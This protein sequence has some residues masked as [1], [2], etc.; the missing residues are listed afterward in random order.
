[1]I[2]KSLKEKIIGLKQSI[3]NLR[4]SV[5]ARGPVWLHLCRALT[6]MGA[7]H[8]AEN[9]TQDLILNVKEIQRR[10]NMLP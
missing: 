9:Q 8:F 6:S 2:L 7:G 4:Y 10:P 3:A 5:K 1:M